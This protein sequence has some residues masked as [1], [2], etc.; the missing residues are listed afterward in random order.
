MM[1]LCNSINWTAVGS[2]AT[3]VSAILTLIMLGI[4]AWQIY[5]LKKQ[6]IEENRAR[7]CFS[8]VAWNDMFLLKIKNVGKEVAY[9]IKLKITGPIIDDH[10]SRNVK[11]RLKKLEKR[12]FMMESEHTDYYDISFCYTENR[13]LTYEPGNPNIKEE[14]ISANVNKWLDNHFDDKI[15]ITGTYCD[16]YQINEQF[17]ISDFITGSIIYHD[18]IT[19]ELKILNKTLKK[20]KYEPI[21]LPIH[22]NSQ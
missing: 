13:I 3:A 19:N 11:E 20:V 22:D 16:K 9:N 21:K 14:F 4:N 5:I 2:I 12:P 18:D 7:L 8:I 6:R 15:T 17:S 10:Y 1:T